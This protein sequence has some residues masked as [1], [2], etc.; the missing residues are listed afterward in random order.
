MGNLATKTSIYLPI[1]SISLFCNQSSLQ[2]LPHGCPLIPP[3]ATYH[4]TMHWLSP[5]PYKPFSGLPLPLNP[6]SL[7]VQIS[8]FP[9]LN[10]KV[11]HWPHGQPPHSS[12]ALTAHIYPFPLPQK[13]PPSYIP[14]WSLIPHAATTTPDRY[15]LCSQLMLFELNCSENEGGI[16][17]D[18]H[19]FHK[20]RI[21]YK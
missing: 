9:L 3:H 4:L 7:W 16:E 12:G 17:V 8:S 1:G 20:I 15:L 5:H 13:M 6:T 19:V 11:L 10:F 18:F 2:Y 14:M 21:F